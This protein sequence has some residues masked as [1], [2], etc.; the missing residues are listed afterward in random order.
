[1]K[2]IHLK[3]QLWNNRMLGWGGRFFIYLTLIGMGIV[4]AHGILPSDCLNIEG[5]DISF[6]EKYSLS[7]KAPLQKCK[8]PLPSYYP[9]NI[10]DEVTSNFRGGW[11]SGY[12]A[13][14]IIARYLIIDR[15]VTKGHPFHFHGDDWLDS[16]HWHWSLS[17]LSECLLEVDPGNVVMDRIDLTLLKLG[18]ARRSGNKIKWRRKQFGT[19]AREQFSSFLQNL[20]VKLSVNPRFIEKQKHD[21]DIPGVSVQTVFIL[22]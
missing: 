11:L 3:N 22:N 2:I 20:E 12:D 6:V 7:Y 17:R 19:K 13:Y 18:M 9:E 4:H 16:P 15:G 21:K 8:Y 5:H 10:P 1:M 14:R